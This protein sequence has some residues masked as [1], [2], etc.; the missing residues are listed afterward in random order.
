[1]DTQQLKQYRQVG[2]R[3]F[4]KLLIQKSD[5]VVDIDFFVDQSIRNLSGLPPRPANTT[6][7][8]GLYSQRNGL[9]EYRI[10]ACDRLHQLI[11]ELPS[12]H[13]I[14]HEIDRFIRLFSPTTERSDEVVPYSHLLTKL[15]RP[16]EI[17]AAPPS[18]STEQLLEIAGSDEFADKIRLMTKSVN[19]TIAKFNINTSL[20]KAHFLAQVMYE[21][22]GFGYL[23]EIWR[24]TEKQM[25]YEGN[26]ELGNTKPGD[27][28]YFLGRGLIKLTGRANYQAFSD[29]IG[30]DFVS[31][32]KMLKESP[33]AA[34]AAGWYWNNHN[35]N[36]PAD[37]DDL[38]EVTYRISGN[39]F[40]IEERST[41]LRRAKL[42]VM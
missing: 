20:R 41:Y 19:D 24:E 23:R 9:K 11:D 32:P 36:E 15:A 10:K 28:H 33:Y 17:K 21:S 2:L 27:G 3:Q 38:A 40:G 37:R 13:P 5:E 1:M 42:V 22:K 29:A 34:L 12:L 18:L 6:P 31:N 26:K 4:Y 7:Y 25:A 16:V 30:V 35:I 39:D 14:D 8:I